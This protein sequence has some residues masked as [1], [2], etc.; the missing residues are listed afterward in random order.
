MELRYSWPA[1][2]FS[3]DIVIIFAFRESAEAIDKNL[4]ITIIKC[5][6]KPKHQP[7]FLSQLIEELGFKRQDLDFIEC[8]ADG[9]QKKNGE[10]FTASVVGACG[11]QDQCRSYCYNHLSPLSPRFLRNIFFF[12]F[13]DLLLAR[14]EAGVVLQNRVFIKLRL[15]NCVFSLRE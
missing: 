8:G 1:T 3:V 12:N 5:L 4:G 11:Y 15:A 13:L 6:E 2:F 7:I 9:E 14:S 10:Y